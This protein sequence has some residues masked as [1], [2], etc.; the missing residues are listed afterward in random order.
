MLSLTSMYRLC[1]FIFI[2]L[3]PFGRRHQSLVSAVQDTTQNNKGNV[4][5]ED[6]TKPNGTT[7]LS[8]LAVIEPVLVITTLDG[9]IY[10]VGQRSGSIKWMMKDDPVVRVPQ[11]P[12]AS[13]EAGQQS[14][15]HLFLPDPKDGSLYMLHSSISEETQDQ[16][17]DTLTKMP[18]TIAQLVTASPCRS[19][20]GLLYTGN[21]VDSWITVNAKTGEKMDVMD[22]DTPVCK[23]PE[24]E[25]DKSDL[26]TTPSFLFGRSL[27]HLSIFDAKTR[28]KKWNITLV[29]Y[30][31]T[32]SLAS[33]TA[34]SSSSSSSSQSYPFLHLTSSTTGKIVTIDLEAEDDGKQRNKTGFKKNV[35]WS[36]DLESPIIAMFE[37]DETGVKGTKKVAF[38]TV[39]DPDIALTQNSVPS[40]YIGES[41]QTRQAYA[42]S[43]LVPFEMR[44]LSR[45]RN[46]PT[47][48][49]LEGPLEGHP[50][51]HGKEGDKKRKLNRQ[52]SRIEEYFQMLI[53][54]YYEYPEFSKEDF[55]SS[56]LLKQMDKNLLPAPAYPVIVSN[57]G[58][59]KLPFH[60]KETEE[61]K[62]EDVY[63]SMMYFYTAV[64]VTAGLIV[65]A[66]FLNVKLRKPLPAVNTDLIS[67]GKI[68][69]KSQ[70]IIGRGSAGTC[71]YRGVFE[72]KTDIAVKRVIREHFSLAQREI[73]LLRSLQHPNVVRYY[74]TESDNLFKYIAIELAEMSLADWIDIKRRRLTTSA[75]DEQIEDDLLSLSEV[76]VLEEASKGLS[77]LHSINVIHRDIKPHNILISPKAR[78]K[79]TGVTRKI[80]ISDFGVSKTLSSASYSFEGA[81]YMTNDFISTTRVAKGT[82]GWIA[83]EVLLVKMTDDG[84]DKKVISKQIDIFSLGCLYY[85]V[86]TNGRHPF[87]DSLERQTNIISNKTDLSHL[88]KREE[89]IGKLSL[90]QCM[91]SADPLDRPR[92]QT[93]LHH[94]LFWSNAKQLQFLQDV[95]DRVENEERNSEVKTRL[96]TGSWDV[97]QG[98]WKRRLPD[99]VQRE[100]DQHR[101]Y[102]GSSVDHLTRAIR[103]KK[104]HYRELSPEVKEILGDIPDG[105]M[106]Y[107]N[108]K[109]PRLIH[110]CYIA[111]QVCKMEPMFKAYYDQDA[112]WEFSYPRLPSNQSAVLTYSSKSSF[113][114]MA[115]FTPESMSSTPVKKARLTG[116]KARRRK[117]KNRASKIGNKDDSDTIAGGD[118]VIDESEGSSSE[119]EECNEQEKGS[120]QLK[121]QSM[122]W[123]SSQPSSES[124]KST[125]TKYPISP[126][127]P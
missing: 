85:Y 120:I 124:P 104:H 81:A 58:V 13:S 63:S 101:K 88:S 44:L 9:M 121:P 66:H 30:S 46:R 35:L 12:N 107:F 97:V 102:F 89:D 118:A 40:L 77:H 24:D 64:F 95:S 11:M 109:F 99:E 69:Y 114:D 6:P 47:L 60:D 70:D 67:V 5:I 2:F 68:T 28:T 8:S 82:E 74:S 45:K 94:P 78:S 84:D 57:E 23:K 38:T 93:V 31:S 16:L 112:S 20:D 1:A 65:T 55:S 18:F 37:F 19:S 117:A 4:T 25:D 10:A 110:H 73:D 123:K 43:A 49:L 14:H 86:F 27:Y 106:S 51:Q 32:A 39:G 22:S 127:S 108:S 91:I 113:A 48:P 98:N 29:D 116:S 103:N 3:I 76:H 96:E 50:H 34:G 126:S 62:L 125:P 83:P 61:D 115:S 41:P 17:K 42:I 26:E 122:L 92:I 36:L 54:G 90:I 56:L 80:F 100:L 59:T 72:G 15:E 105:F 87:G 21:K 7:T 119:S 71:V 79:K 52:H 75:T 111:M 33:S 53:Y